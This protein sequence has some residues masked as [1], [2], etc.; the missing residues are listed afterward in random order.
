MLLNRHKP[1]LA[2]VTCLTSRC[3]RSPTLFG[4]YHAC[5][6]VASHRMAVDLVRRQQQSRPS[7]SQYHGLKV[8]GHICTGICDG[9]WDPI[10]CIMLIGFL[11]DEEPG[12]ANVLPP[13][14]GTN[15]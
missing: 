11:Y 10:F 8:N 3:E 5:N 9:R 7:P 1:T 13:R 12:R 2:S 6:S 15:R 4:G 14:I